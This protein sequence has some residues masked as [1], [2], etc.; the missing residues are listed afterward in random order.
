MAGAISQKQAREN[1]SLGHHGVALELHL[2]GARI[3]Q[4]GVLVDQVRPRLRL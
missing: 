3:Q 2:V 1:N 4:D